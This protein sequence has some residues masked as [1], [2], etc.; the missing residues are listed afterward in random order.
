MEHEETQSV[1]AAAALYL[2]VRNRTRDS[3]DSELNFALS[4]SQVQILEE[5]IHN[6]GE[7]IRGIDLPAYPVHEVRNNLAEDSPPPCYYVEN[8]N[9]STA[10]NSLPSSNQRSD[11]I[12]TYE[13]LPPSTPATA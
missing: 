10:D 4:L 1:A 8:A 3:F 12:V 11:F 9:Y 5:R 2:P 6:S 7:S 13:Q